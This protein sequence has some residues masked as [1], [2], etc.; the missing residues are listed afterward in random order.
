MTVMVLAHPKINKKKN[1]KQ[2]PSLSIQ[3]QLSLLTALIQIFL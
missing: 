3:T 1:S 2:M